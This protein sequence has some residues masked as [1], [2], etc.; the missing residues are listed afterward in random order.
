MCEL[1]LVISQPLNGEVVGLIGQSGSGKSTFASVISG[2]SKAD[3]GVIRFQETELLQYAA[4]SKMEGIQHVFQDPFSSLNESLTVLDCISEP[5]VIMEKRK[6]KACLPAILEVLVKVQL[7]AD[8]T[9]LQ[10]RLF[11]CSGGMRQRI[12]LARA[13]VVKPKLLIADEI[14]AMLDPSTSATILRV[15]KEQQMKTG[16]SM[17]FITHDLSLARKVADRLVIMKDGL[18]IEEGPTAKL[19]Q[20][21]SHHYTAHLIEASLS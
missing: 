8:E 18:F 3:H 11:E 14:T 5:L 21:Q 19:F 13:L 15:L 7:P 10:K 16:F 9:F 20:T 4:S 6:A 1:R 2:F 12:A 17:L